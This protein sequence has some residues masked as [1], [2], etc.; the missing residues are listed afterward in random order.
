MTTSSA[1]VGSSLARLTADRP[2]LVAIATLNAVFG[3]VAAWILFPLTFG[4][5]AT[6]YRNGALGIPQG[7]IA[8]DFL[9]PPLTGILL[10]PL[11]W[12]SVP[13]AS[14]AMSLI[15]LAL[16]VA[17]VAI[18]TERLELV[19]RVLILVAALGFLPVTYE[20]I[21]GQVTLVIA[22][23]VL[24]V[25][26]RDGLGRG[27]AVGLVLGLFA[28]PMLLPLLVW[29]LVRRRRALA[30]ALV[31]AVGVTVAGVALLGPDIYR[32][33]IDALVGTGQITRPGNLALTALGNPAVYVPLTVVAAVLAL[34]AIVADERRGFAAALVS[35]MLVAPFT[36]M[37]QVSI[38]LV[39]V[40]PALA[41][42][43]RATRVLALV[44]NPAVLV[45]FIAW[46]GATLASLVPW[47]RRAA[48]SR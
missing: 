42:A 20:L 45:A 6:I 31:T 38:L 46:A 24:A 26:D 40:R 16:L 7:V 12:L 8:E 36:L 9:Y 21:T 13:G 18:E 39:A 33:W 35:A 29:M 4:S 41:V 30:S 15:G 47:P 43:P 37:Y 19:D 22:A 14:L 5:D 2:L 1:A 23:A 3:I 27:V 48:A 28:K 34:W 44:A 17:G 25:R 10:T 11:T 32:A